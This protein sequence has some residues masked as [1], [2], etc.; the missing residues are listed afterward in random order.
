MAPILACSGLTKRFGDF[1][2]VAGVTLSVEPGEI[3]AIIGPNG[4]GKS[5]LFNLFAGT[6][7][8]GGAIRFKGQDITRLPRFRRARM[9]LV[10]A[11]QI[12]S[13]FPSL[14]VTENVALAA[15][16]DSAGYRHI[17]SGPGLL[18]RYER[19]AHGV[20]A[21]VGLEAEADRLASELSH[22]DRKRLEIALA[23]ATEA[24]VLLLDEPT[25]GMSPRES[26]IMADLIADIAR[27]CTIVLIEHDV[28]M[29]LALSR[30]VVVLH[31]G[32]VLAEGSPEEIETNREVQDAYLGG[33][34]E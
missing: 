21:R 18:G 28:D 5:T 11:D 2:A 25:S 17:F 24:D 34:R 9:G 20:L 19:A 29:V 10:K 22:G 3:K 32:R 8:N 16:A 15:Y 7:V 13:I 30:S 27:G 31:R 6:P 4:A 1:V 23:L 26:G 14:T 33:Y 12:V